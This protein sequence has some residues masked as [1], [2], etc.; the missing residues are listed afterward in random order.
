[1]PAFLLL[2]CIRRQKVAKIRPLWKTLVYQAIDP[3]PPPPTPG[4]LNQKNAP[5]K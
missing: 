5:K 2:G 3:R 1:M 4:H